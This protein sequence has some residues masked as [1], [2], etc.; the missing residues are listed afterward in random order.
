MLCSVAAPPSSAVRR[1][2]GSDALGSLLA[3]VATAAAGRLPPPP[4]AWS[5][6]TV[7]RI[8]CS[9][10]AATVS[11]ALTIASLA[12]SPSVPFRSNGA[13]KPGAGSGERR[14]FVGM[15]MARNA[16]GPPA[17]ASLTKS[18]AVI[19]PMMLAVSG[20]LKAAPE[21]IAGAVFPAD[22][23]E[24]KVTSIQ[25]LDGRSLPT[26]PKRDRPLPSPG[27]SCAARTTPK[28]SLK[29][30]A[31]RASTPSFWPP[32]KETPVAKSLLSVR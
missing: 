1:N 32:A 11:A 25:A 28:T 29:A 30:L 12:V 18:T 4:G 24:S 19:V 27:V 9:I 6:V 20:R 5:S 2:P 7:T 13:S 21:V 23:A 26:V 16:S 14:L 3:P 22:P 10:G 17:M 15:V 8:V 31:S